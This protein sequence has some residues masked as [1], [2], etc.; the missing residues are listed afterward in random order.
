MRTA[1]SALLA[2]LLFS[3]LVLYACASPV[4]QGYDVV[5]YFNLADADKDD[6]FGVLGISSY[7]CRLKTYDFSGDEK[8]PLGLYE[9]WF[10]KPENVALFEKDPWKYAPKYGGFCSWGIATEVAPSWPW[11]KEHMGPPA[12][13][14]DA[15]RVYKDALYLNYWQSIR[16]SF[17][18]DAEKHIALADKRWIELY[19]AL[20]AGPFNLDCQSSIC[21]S[22]LQPLHN[23]SHLPS[24]IPDVQ[25]S[26]TGFLTP[27]SDLVKLVGTTQLMVY[28][29]HER[30][31]SFL[32]GS[33]DSSFLGGSGGGE[34]GEV[35][36]LG[37]LLGGS[38]EPSNGNSTSGGPVET[39]PLYPGLTGADVEVLNSVE[40]NGDLVRPVMMGYD[41]VSYFDIKPIQEGVIGHPQYACHLATY[42]KSRS[43]KK[44]LGVYEF[45]FANKNNMK[46]FEKDPWKYAPKY[47]G[48]CSWG[49][50]TELE[51]QGWP[52]T[53]S[54]LGPPGQPWDGW[55]VHDDGGLYINYWPSIAGSFF[56]DPEK[57]IRLGN[58][59][60]K[61]WW[62]DL[63]AG[64]FNTHCPNAACVRIQ[65]NLSPPC[66]Q[67]ATCK[68][69][70]PEVSCIV[71]KSVGGNTTKDHAPSDTLSKIKKQN[72]KPDKSQKDDSVEL[73][74]T[75]IELMESSG[76]IL[77]SSVWVICASWLGFLAMFL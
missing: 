71:R 23:I 24:D 21:F 62:G 1:K 59:R 16:G 25:C 37:S 72:G 61:G 2:A 74:S 27:L 47:G 66:P 9:F 73:S 33:G 50:A 4:L 54:F 58:E 49:I 41:V 11:A 51:E 46:R 60:W 63:K 53:K 56:S 70:I 14:W 10:S 17:F 43:K 57:N 8:R 35:E 39:S 34:N 67:D 15:W 18:A 68:G 6:D 19:G 31:P 65:Q 76:R 52:W 40:N 5:E 69:D 64:P 38:G 29:G 55:T 22:L 7:S 42:D 12:Q 3:S 28:K 75:P 44:L 36:P 77:L 45:W 32:G 26:S 20:N 48:F 30:A 13:P